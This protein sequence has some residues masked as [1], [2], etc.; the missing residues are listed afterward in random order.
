MSK[1]KIEKISNAIFD[2]I[3]WNFVI[4]IGIQTGNNIIS[5]YCCCSIHWSPICWFHRYHCNV[6][7]IELIVIEQITFQYGYLACIW[8]NFSFCNGFK[9]LSLVMV[10]IGDTPMVNGFLPMQSGWKLVRIFLM[11]CMI[12]PAKDFV[13]ANEEPCLPLPYTIW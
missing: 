3:S 4:K 8:S 13:I 2:A 1:V 7:H 9:Q 6:L 10:P 11:G 12:L 5:T